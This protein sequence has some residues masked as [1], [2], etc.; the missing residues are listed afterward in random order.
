MPCGKTSAKRTCPSHSLDAGVRSQKLTSRRTQFK[1]LTLLPKGMLFVSSEMG[2]F[3][4]F[5]MAL[6]S[7]LENSPW[8]VVM[9]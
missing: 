1:M 4:A 9:E 2:N 8:S 5:L 3:E 6:H 7:L